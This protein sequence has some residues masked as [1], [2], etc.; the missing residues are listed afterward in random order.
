MLTEE[1]TN[2]GEGVLG[3][4]VLLFV[5]TLRRFLFVAQGLSLTLV[6]VGVVLFFT[7]TSLALGGSRLATRLVTIFG[8]LGINGVVTAHR[9]PRA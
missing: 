3:V 4:W 8:S 9:A 5:F 7:T 6:H 1:L 2:T